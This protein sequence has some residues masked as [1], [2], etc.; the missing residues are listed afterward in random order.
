MMDLLGAI[1]AGAVSLAI[2][3]GALACIGKALGLILDQER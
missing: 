2:V 1:V 3:W